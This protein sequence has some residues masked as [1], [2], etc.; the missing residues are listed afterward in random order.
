VVETSD[1][2]S[3]AA[4][5]WQRR[6]EDRPEEILDAAVAVF[7]DQGYARAKLEDVARQAGVSKGT[8]YLY[9]A[10]KEEL[11]REMVRT[12]IVPTV[13]EG[14]VAFEQWT[15][16]SRQ[17]LEDTIK[18]YWHVMTGE[19]TACMVRLVKAEMHQFPELG[20]FYF[21]EVILRSRRLLTAVLQRGVASGEFRAGVVEHGSRIIPGLVAQ[22]AESRRYFNTFDPDARPDAEL[23]R[24]IVD[25]V[26]HGVA[27]SPSAS[28][29]GAA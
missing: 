5:R 16:T 10:S 23:V 26:E 22:M 7:G 18:R 13:E 27:A 2:N 17:L 11:F 3:L 19:R 29:S 24:A 14:E 8:L 1:P 21:D 6:P 15:G 20:Q 25:F 28:T 4:P 12:R 9:F